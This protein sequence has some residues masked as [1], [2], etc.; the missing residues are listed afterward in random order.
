MSENLKLSNQVCFPIYSLA[1]EVVSLYRPILQRLDLTYPQY[2]VM[3][4]LWEEGTQN[5]SEIGSKLNLDS[6]TLTPL[7]KRLAQKNLIERNRSTHDERIVQIK[8]TASGQAMKTTAAEVPEQILNS[9]N[10]S[11]EQLEALK[12][13]I[14]NIL[15]QIKK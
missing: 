4:V 2:L 9:L 1:K 12:A 7:L 6:G 5:V 11:I 8:L 10:V 13:G 14:E 3:L 15:N